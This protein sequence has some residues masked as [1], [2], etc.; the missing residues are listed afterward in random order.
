[1]IRGVYGVFFNAVVTVPIVFVRYR[2]CG[3]LIPGEG[4]RL[5]MGTKHLLSVMC[6]VCATGSA[7]AAQV[8]FDDAGD[9]SGWG[10]SEKAAGYVTEE[11][12]FADV[13][14]DGQE[15]W[16]NSWNP[17]AADSGS[18]M[19][20]W[21]STGVIIEAEKEYTLTAKMAAWDTGTEGDEQ[22]SQPAGA[23]DQIWIAMED[24]TGATITLAE[25]YVWPDNS[26]GDSQGYANYSTTFNTYGGNNAASINAEIG[27][28]ISSINWWN[29]FSVSEVSVSV[30]PE[31]ATFGLFAMSALA[32]LKRRK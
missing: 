10:V 7:Q 19:D 31:P 6:V 4:E 20:I 17:S 22:G 16:L 9:L 8:W 18:W 26:T 1:L 3:I 25:N 15:F 13:D 24:W 11:G 2:L 28:A 14:A 30:V 5:M 12:T 21:A 27:V 23:G 32:C 29:N